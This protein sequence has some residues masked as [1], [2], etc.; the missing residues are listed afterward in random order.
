MQKSRLTS[1]SKMEIFI[2]AL[3]SGITENSP[4]E[5]FQ[6]AYEEAGY[7]ISLDRV[8]D[9]FLNKHYLEYHIKMMLQDNS[10]DK[11]VLGDD[12]Y[13]I[14]LRAQKVISRDPDLLE[15]FVPSRGRVFFQVPVFFEHSGQPC[16]GMIDVLYISDEGVVHVLDLKTS[17]RGVWSFSNDF[18]YKR[19]YIQAAMYTLG[20]EKI[21]NGEMVF[22][23]H[24][25][26]E[27]IIELIQQANEIAQFG[28]IVVGTAD[29]DS[30]EGILWRLRQEDKRF[31]FNGGKVNGTYYKGL[32]ELIEDYKWHKAHD[33]WAKARE[34]AQNK[35]ELLLNIKYD[36]D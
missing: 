3:P 36:N 10:H 29:K 33:Y 22:V 30:N 15:Y 26:A 27:R 20:I 25:E 5:M 8:I 28:F 31:A 2:N 32:H 13:Q 6:S 16:K 4:E 24:P 7:S 34:L 1:G 21:K 17:G 18:I 11:I 35:G 12:E 9:T 14:A 19:Y 23:D